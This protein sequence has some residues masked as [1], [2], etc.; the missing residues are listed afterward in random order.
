MAYT[1]G[2]MQQCDTTYRL[3][4]VSPRRVHRPGQR[5]GAELLAV[6]LPRL[7]LA[8]TVALILSTLGGTAWAAEGMASWYGEPHHGR[9]M[10]NGQVFDMYDPTTTASSHFALGTW[11]R[12]ANIANG[13]TVEVQVRD[14][15]GG[16]VVDLSYAAFAAIASPSTGIIRITYDVIGGPG[17]PPAP[18]AAAALAA[19]PPAPAAATRLAPA[20]V[21]VPAPVA[22]RFY[23]VE[24]GDTLGHI[25]ER[26]GVDS[27]TLA[28][29][30]GMSAD[31]VIRIGQELQITTAATHV[32]A[33]DETLSE[34]AERY[35]MS[36]QTLIRLNNLPD[37]DHI[38]VDQT[39]RLR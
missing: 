2:C 27:L 18:R 10:A 39:L 25:A 6:G 8:A 34:I 20:T 23:T 36:V 33:P 30:N 5:L 16:H 31:A 11:L 3:P 38:T 32:I 12:V 28:R 19:P 14:R 21:V 17:Q 26:F 24:E 13:R 9:R 7:M 1:P 4:A 22:G 15:G 35:A 37:A 29:V